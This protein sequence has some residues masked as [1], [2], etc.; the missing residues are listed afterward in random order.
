MATQ[1]ELVD[2]L[3]KASY[4]IHKKSL[5]P[6]ANWVIVSPKIAEIIENLDIK[7]HRRKKLEA[8]LKSQN[9]KTSE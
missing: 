9:E 1:K 3:I 5:E 8:I 7:K 2:K 4:L 6:Q